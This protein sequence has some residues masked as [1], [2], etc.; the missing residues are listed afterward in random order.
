MR[1][2][3]PQIGPLLL[4][5]LG[6]VPTYVDGVVVLDVIEGGNPWGRFQRARPWEEVN[7][8]KFTGTYHCAEVPHDWALTESEGGIVAQHLPLER[9]EPA[10]AGVLNSGNTNIH[11]SGDRL[12]VGTYR[13]FGFDF[14]RV[15]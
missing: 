11:F 1:R 6:L 9:F 14:E 5:H 8:A 13:A 2:T 4:T 7:L 10:A 12:R 3:A 15:E